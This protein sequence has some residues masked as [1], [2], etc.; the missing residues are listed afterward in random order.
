MGIQSKFLY[1]STETSPTPSICSI[2]ESMMSFYSAPT[3]PTSEFYSTTEPTTPISTTTNTTY[4]EDCANFNLED[5]EFDTSHRFL[6]LNDF[7]PKIPSPDYGDPW[8]GDSLPSSMSFADELFCDGKVVPLAP[9]PPLKLPPR[10]S[11]QSN[12]KVVRP[13]SPRTPRSVLNKVAFSRQCLW[14]DDFDPFMVAIENVRGKNH[15]R[16]RSMSPSSRAQPGESVSLGRPTM[17]S[18]LDSHE[19]RQPNRSVSLRWASPRE[20]AREE[21]EEEQKSHK[22]QQLY[23][24]VSES[25]SWKVVAEPKGVAM[26]RRVRK[27]AD[28]ISAPAQIKRQKKLWFPLKGPSNRKVSDEENKVKDQNVG[29]LSKAT[30]LS[31]IISFKSINKTQHNQDEKAMTQ[32]SKMSI[33]QYKPRLSSLCLGYGSKYL[34]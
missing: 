8:R 16:A 6:H 9:T 30:F 18:G 10:L 20:K 15:K 3:S 25:K 34:D 19:L 11:A 21:E 32:A 5:F 27:P 31:R 12:G 13:L 14:N 1:T 29:L 33:V 24:L 2:E 26:A 23:G 4:Y 17:D 28:P 7:E 22:E